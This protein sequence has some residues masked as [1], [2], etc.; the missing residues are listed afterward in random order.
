MKKINYLFSAYTDNEQHI[1]MA[2]CKDEGNTE[3]HLTYAHVQIVQKSVIQPS[4]LIIPKEEFTQDE[5]LSSPVLE[6][7][8]T[9]SNEVKREATDQGRASLAHFL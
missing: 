2:Q 7:P 3:T 9:M 1:S 4:R 5:N 6:I 8:T